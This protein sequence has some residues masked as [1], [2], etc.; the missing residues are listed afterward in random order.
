MNAILLIGW[1]LVLVVS[2]QGGVIALKKT[3]LL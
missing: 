2:Y 3:D 1:L